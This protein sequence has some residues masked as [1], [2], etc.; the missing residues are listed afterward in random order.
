LITNVKTAEY[1]SKLLLDI[2]GQLNESVET[3]ERGC[4]PDEFTA[5]RRCVG[6]LI[7][8]IF[9]DILEPIYVKHPTLKPPEL[10]M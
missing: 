5:Y 4:T 1:V 2:N 8:S 10:E 7:N 9:E 3:V 6:R